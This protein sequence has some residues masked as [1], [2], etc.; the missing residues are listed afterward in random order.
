MASQLYVPCTRSVPNIFSV[1][2]GRLCWSRSSPWSWSADFSPCPLLTDP[3]DR[4]KRVH[5]FSSCLILN[6]YHGCVAP[7]SPLPSVQGPSAA[8]WQEVN[9]RFIHLN[10]RDLKV[11][12]RKRRG[13][14]EG[15]CQVCESCFVFW[16][17][18]PVCAGFWVGRAQ[19]R[20]FSLIQCVFYLRRLLA[21]LV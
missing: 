16:G 5:V 17:A 11:W 15:T 20:A 19:W 13:G 4:P 2:A 8:I 12:N 18:L 9:E 10:E 7:L 1:T 3:C 21:D 6:V 14:C